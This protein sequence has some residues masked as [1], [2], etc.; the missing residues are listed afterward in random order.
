MTLPPLLPSEVEGSAGGSPEALGG[1][2]TERVGGSE[3]APKWRGGGKWL[4]EW[5][6]V[7]LSRKAMNGESALAEEND[8]RWIARLCYSTSI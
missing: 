6:G 2:V 8:D 1:P 4:R 7:A 5:S 3:V